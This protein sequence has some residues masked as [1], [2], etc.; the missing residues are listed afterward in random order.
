MSL[1]LLAC[2]GWVLLLIPFIGLLYAH[3]EREVGD[4]IKP[5][6]EEISEQ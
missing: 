6:P 3:G 5:V 2:I 1:V 4:G